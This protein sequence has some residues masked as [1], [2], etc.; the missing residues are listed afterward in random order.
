MSG[1]SVALCCYNAKSRLEPTLRHLLSQTCSRELPWEVILVDNAS[2]D[3]SADHARSLWPAEP[4]APLR[5]VSEPRRGAAFARLRAL[6]E[7]QHPLILFVD[8]DN[9]LAP[10]A[11][12][13]ALD[14]MGARPDVGACGGQGTAYLPQ[15]APEWFSRFSRSYAVGA[16]GAAS[17]YVEGPYAH[18]YGA[19]LVV[20][21]AAARQLLAADYLPLL[22]GRVGQDLIA[23]EDT[24]LC[25]ALRLAG[26]RL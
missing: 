23:G 15:P 1:I 7:A 8:D 22:S 10:D 19:G 13:V 20:R 24:E 21:T 3:G 2:T 18:L 12:Q 25:F 26:W 14:T 6:A 11:L 5:V 16:Q 17:G 4:P 9:H